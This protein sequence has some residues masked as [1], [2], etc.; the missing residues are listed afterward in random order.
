MG[1]PPAPRGLPGADRRAAGHTG[2]GH[3]GDRARAADARGRRAADVRVRTK[4]RQHEGELGRASAW[5]GFDALVELARQSSEELI[6]IAEALVEDSEVALPYRGRAY[7]YPTSF[8]LVHAAEH[9]VEHRTEVK[10]AL[11]QLGVETPD[12]DAW[13][14]AGAAGYGREVAGRGSRS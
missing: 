1:Q 7:R 3:V 4:G 6:A 13:F 10:V 11:A 9:G 2:P 8:F 12:L 14:Y 5:P